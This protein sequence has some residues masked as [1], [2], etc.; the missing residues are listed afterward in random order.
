[1]STK[2]RPD[3]ALRAD[4][5]RNRQRVLEAAEAVLAERGLQAGIEEVARRAGVGVGTVCRNFA[6]KDDLVA[7][8]LARRCEELLGQVRE[9]ASAADP[10]AAFER[11]VVTLAEFSARYKALAEEIAAR[12][13]EIPVRPELKADLHA[14]FDQLVRRAQSAGALRKDV[15][16]ADIMLVLSG[17]AH[18]AVAARVDPA[19]QRRFVRIVLDG[20][21]PDRVD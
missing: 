4:A 13:G 3:Q 8:V 1:M 10:G 12:V 15:T 6:T 9:A 11:V 18:A 14:A 21:R 19:A 16:E 2:I 7:E 17:I 20:L 5:R